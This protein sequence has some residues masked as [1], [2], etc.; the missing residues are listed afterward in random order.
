MGDYDNYSI[1]PD[2]T[3]AAPVPDAGEAFD[4]L[5]ESDWWGSET[6]QATLSDMGGGSE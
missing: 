6:Q 1:A 5:A 4:P 3:T 2:E